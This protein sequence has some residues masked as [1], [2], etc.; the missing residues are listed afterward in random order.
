[1]FELGVKQPKLSCEIGVEGHA[2]VAH[3]APVR[4]GSHAEKGGCK[5]KLK[6]RGFSC[7]NCI[8]AALCNEDTSPVCADAHWTLSRGHLIAICD[9]CRQRCA[10]GDAQLANLILLKRV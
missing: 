10:P 6:L 4:A 1:M 2:Y 7:Q 3:S 5:E 8:F 9:T